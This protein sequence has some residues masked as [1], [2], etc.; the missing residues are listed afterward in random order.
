MA[1]NTFYNRTTSTVVIDGVTVKGIAEGNAIRVVEEADGATTVKGLDRAMT[2]INNDGRARLEIDLLPTSPYIAVANGIK[3][4]QNEGSGRL[5]DGSV[6]SGVNEL[7]KLQG[8]ALARR[9]DVQTGGEAG[10]N[11]TIIFTVERAV[12]DES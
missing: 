2:N 9:G 6:R 7:E 11:R 10:Q 4:R 12:G 5:M 1:R 8:M 3:R